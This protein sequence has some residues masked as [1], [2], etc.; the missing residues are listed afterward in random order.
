MVWK[1]PRLY[2]LQ[3]LQTDI[4][5]IKNKTQKSL[6]E[7]KILNWNCIKKENCPLKGECQIECVVYKADVLNLSSNSYNWNDNVYVGSTQGPFKLRY[8]EHKSCFTHVIYRHKTILSNYVWEV[9]N[10][11]G[12]D[13]ILKWEI[14]KRWIDI[15]NYVRRKK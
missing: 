12:I 1:K 13:P 2:N 11:F 14:M 3:I 9:K 8:Y 10:K 15:V 6:R 7:I 4:W 5:G